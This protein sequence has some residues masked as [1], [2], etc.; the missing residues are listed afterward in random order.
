MKF[1]VYKVVLNDYDFVLPPSVTDD[2]LDYILFTDKPDM[3][4]KGWQTVNIESDLLDI[5]C[6]KVNRYYKF[7]PYKVLEKY[8]ASLYIDGNIHIKGSIKKLV[9][10]FVASHALIGLV[11]HPK[12]NTVNEEVE[13]CV[14][15][16]KVDS[17]LIYDEY[18]KY[19]SDGFQDQISLTENSVILRWHKDSR[20]KKA[21]EFWWDCFQYSAGRDQISFPYVR[22]KYQLSE[23]IYNCNPNKLNDYFE[24]YPHKQHKLRAD[25]KTYIYLKGYNNSIYRKLFKVSRYCYRFFKRW[26]VKPFSVT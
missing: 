26:C 16:G 9:E 24:W 21:M 20:L 10:D 19:L 4:I 22:E 17:K 25:L 13:A 8:D 1:A 18:K 3:H 23:R 12:R 7:F 2:D 5:P 11:N 6:F 15:S 14:T